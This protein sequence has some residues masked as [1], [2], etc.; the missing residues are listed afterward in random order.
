MR[1]LAL[2]VLFGLFA[3]ICGAGEGAAPGGGIPVPFQVVPSD[4]FAAVIKNWSD[5]S[6]PHY[7][8][9]THMGEWDFAFQPTVTM[10]NNRPTRPDPSLF[11]KAW[12]VAISRVT[13][14]PAP[15][16][17]V[18]D[19]KSLVLQD[20][21]LVLTYTF[22]PPENKASYKAKS[23]ILVAI[24]VR[25]QNELRIIEDTETAMTRTAQA[26]LDD[27]KRAGRV[28]PQQPAPQPLPQQMPQQMPQP[29]PQQHPQW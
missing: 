5:E 21:Q 8:I 12:L 19:V 16:Q 1:V 4:H 11:E 7:A 18:L 25:Y 15:G 20:G 3:G 2:A 24:P 22:I 9:M 6:M 28:K 10:G 26:E 23:T 13:D 29:M 14:A 27:A 17:K